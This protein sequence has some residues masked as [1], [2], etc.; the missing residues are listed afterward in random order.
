MQERILPRHFI[1]MEEDIVLV[2]RKSK[3]SMQE[4]REVEGKSVIRLKNNIIYYFRYKNHV[5]HSQQE[6]KRF[7]QNSC[8]CNKRF[9]GHPVTQQ[10]APTKVL[11]YR[12][13]TDFVADFGGP[14]L[15]TRGR[16]GVRTKRSVCLFPCKQTH[17]YHLQKIT[18]FD[19]VGYLNAFNNI[20]TQSVQE[21]RLHVT[22]VFE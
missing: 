14:N 3:I 5:I 17:R 13:C 7:M 12:S 20:G 18:S 22:F 1:S 16:R 21:F 9:R 15:T 2:C 6:V 8:E 10:V 4:G 19:T 11:T